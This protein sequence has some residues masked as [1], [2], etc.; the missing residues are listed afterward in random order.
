MVTLLAAS[1]AIRGQ[2]SMAADAKPLER[3]WTVAVQGGFSSTFQL[4]LGGEFGEGPDFH[5]RLTTSVNNAWKDGDSIS[6]FGWSTS[7]IPS[8][9]ANWQAG[10]SYRM[11]AI[12][13]GRHALYLGGGVQRWLLPSVKTG[14]QDWL[15]AGSLNYA[16][17]IKHLPLLV[18]QDSWSLLRSPLPKGSL[19]YTQISTQHP[20]WRRGGFQILLRHGPQHTYSWGFYGTNGNR[21]VRY[22]GAIVVGWKQT[23]FEAAYRQQFGLQDGIP[24]THFWTVQV[25]RQ[26]SGLFHHH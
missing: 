4:T 25:T 7:D 8:A 13:H 14:A 3:T 16:V 21:V 11:R 18:T 24:Y 20:L 2:K 26:M 5:N 15:A 12:H 17:A 1:L 22:T 10:L 23:F 19:V 9:T 6:M